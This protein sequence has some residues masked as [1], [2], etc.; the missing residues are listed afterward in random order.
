MQSKLESTAADNDKRMTLAQASAGGTYRVLEI[1]GQ[2]C[3]E[4]L[5]RLGISVGSVINSATVV[6]NGP[7]VVRHGRTD[8]A[9]GH[10]MARRIVVEETRL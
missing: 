5:M 3:R 10:G 2:E 4:N 6:H 1:A 8:I 9:I 7:V